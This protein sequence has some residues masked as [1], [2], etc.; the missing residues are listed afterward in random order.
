M[1][2]LLHVGCGLATIEK[3][4]AA[5]QDGTWQEVRFDISED[6]NPDIVGTLLDMKAVEDNSIDAIYSSHNIEHVYYHEVL[7][8]LKEF[9][10]V[11]TRGGIA[12]IVCPDI[13]LIC[14]SVKEYGVD[15]P[16]YT[17]SKGPISALD[18]LYGHGSSIAN[19]HTYM[20]HK[21]GFDLKLLAK[22]L[23]QAGFGTF[24]G[25]RIKR[26][27]ELMFVASKVKISNEAIQQK[28]TQYTAR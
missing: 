10:R 15:G 3:L 2:K 18:I 4:P 27:K 9:R 24:H 13:Q 7:P 16:L 8:V 19:G 21:T 12:I 28:Y 6:V 11:L 23:E 5:F 17:S 14:D 22:R 1:K 26:I 20:A 25:R